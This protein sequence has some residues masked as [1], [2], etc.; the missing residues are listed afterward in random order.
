[1]KQVNHPY[2]LPFSFGPMNGKEGCEKL[3]LKVHI[4][5]KKPEHLHNLVWINC[6]FEHFV[7]RLFL[8]R[9]NISAKARGYLLLD[10][11]VGNLLHLINSVFCKARHVFG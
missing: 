6:D 8:H 9:N 7:K 10:E 3:K 5:I 2:L 11:R 4:I 1:M